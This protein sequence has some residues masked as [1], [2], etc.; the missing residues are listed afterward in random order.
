MSDD[1]TPVDEPVELDLQEEQPTQVQPMRRERK[2]IEKLTIIET[3][4][5][6]AFDAEPTQFDHRTFR[7]LKGTNEQ[8]WIRNLVAGEGWSPLDFG[9]LVDKGVSLF[10]IRNGT[11]LRP[12]TMPDNTPA[13]STGP[14]CLELGYLADVVVVSTNLLILP[15]E[16]QRFSPRKDVHWYVRSTGLDTKFTMYAFSE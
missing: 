14:N 6:Q 11:Q 7:T 3:I 2:P 10:V 4:V 12:P 9:W 16:S 15:G 1:P 5:H 8:V 13:D